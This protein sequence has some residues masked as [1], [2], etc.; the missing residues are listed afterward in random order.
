MVDN[1]L[2]PQ[3]FNMQKAPNAIKKFSCLKVEKEA[4]LAI[5]KPKEEVKSGDEDY[6]AQKTNK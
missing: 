2:P 1:A 5:L 6:I 4:K 3:I